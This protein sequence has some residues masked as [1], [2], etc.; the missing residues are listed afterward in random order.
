MRISKELAKGTTAMLV[1]SVLSEREM[2]GYEI[3][4]VIA[5][6]S[7]GAFE[8]KEGTLYPILHSLEK[9]GLLS[10]YRAESAQGRERRYYKITPSGLFQL[11]RKR[12]EWSTYTAAVESVVGEG[13]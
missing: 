7:E 1:L 10:S 11:K 3:A 4:G 13:Q 2:Y 12:S 6:R 9:E 8:M 5:G